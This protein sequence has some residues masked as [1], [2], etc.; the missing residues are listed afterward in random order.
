MMREN[1]RFVGGRFGPVRFVGLVLLALTLAVPLAPTGAAQA[2][3]EDFWASTE[4]KFYLHL[5]QYCDRKVSL[6]RW[7]DEFDWKNDLDG[8]GGDVLDPTTNKWTDVFPSFVP[9]HA[10]VTTQT[11]AEMHIFVLSRAV[12]QTTVEAKFDVG[13]AACSGRNG[14]A[15]LIQERVAGFH[16]FVVKCTFDVKGEPN[17]VLKANLTITV[18]AT[19]TYGYGTEDAHASYVKL[20]GVVPAPPTEDVRFFNESE[21]PLIQFEEEEEIVRAE[22]P[23]PE[24]GGGAPAAGPVATLAVLAV[25]VASLSRWFRRS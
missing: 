25:L 19:H 23:E 5:A 9:F 11:T 22:L 3:Q 24:A 2:T 17:P 15:L 14:P 18:S 7:I 6:I 12:D 21:R 10:N 13:Y 8:C 20:N 4:R 16:D 1:P